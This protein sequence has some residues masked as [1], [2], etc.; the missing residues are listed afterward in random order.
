THPLGHRGSAD[1]QRAHLGCGAGGPAEAAHLLQIQA[2]Q[3]HPQA[4]ADSRAADSRAGA[5]AVPRSRVSRSSMAAALS[6]WD[7]GLAISLAVHTTISSRTTRLFSRRVV[8][9]FAPRR[10]AAR[11]IRVVSR[12]AT[13][14][15][16]RSRG[17]PAFFANVE[18]MQQ[19]HG[20]APLSIE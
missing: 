15:L 11:E 3:A 16:P 20:R 18:R 5:S 19:A 2:L 12:T 10:S 8:P 17:K 4:P 9:V 14:V 13:P 1:D 7:T 6:L